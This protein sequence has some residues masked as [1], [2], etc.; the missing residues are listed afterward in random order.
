MYLLPALRLKGLKLSKGE[1]VPGEGKKKSDIV[2]ANTKKEE[3]S[4]RVL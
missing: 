2:K 1:E 4:Q 3:M